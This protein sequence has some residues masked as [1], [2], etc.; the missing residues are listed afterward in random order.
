MFEIAAAASL[1]KDNKAVLIVNPSEHILPNQGRNVNNYTN[2]I[3]SRIMLDTNPPVQNLYKWEPCVYKPIPYKPNLKI[4]GHF[5]SY[6]YFDHNREYIQKL[7]SPIGK[8]EKFIEKKWNVPFDKI[9]AIHVRRGD[10]WKFPDHHPQL[11]PEYFTK[12]AKMADPEEIIVFSDDL[13][14]C[15]DNLH[16]SKPTRYISDEDYIELYIMSQCK[17]LIISNSSFSWWAAFINTKNNRKIYA[18]SIW[19]GKNMIKEGFDIDDL[20]LPNWIKVEI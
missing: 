1:A 17:N 8:I 12:A 11:F 5:Q 20:I 15:Q 10:Y 6:K 9:T 7:F 3:F 18:P 14:W 4:M 19:F 16:F 13:K 2:N